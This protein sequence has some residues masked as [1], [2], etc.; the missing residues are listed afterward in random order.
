M[1]SLRQGVNEYLVYRQKL[2]FKLEDD[3][4]LLFNFV[5]FAET[6]Q[7]KHITTEL[8]MAFATINPNGNPARWTRRLAV[9]RRFAVYWS[10][11]DLKTEIP[12]NL[13]CS[14]YKRQAPYIYTDEEITKLLECSE[15]CSSSIDQYAYFIL[16]GLLVVSGMRLTEA[17]SLNCDDVDLEK[18]IITIRQ[19]KFR[20]SRHIPIHESTVAILK[21]FS[22]YRNRQ[23]PH[24]VISRFL[25]NH[26]GAQLNACTVRKIFRNRLKK[27]GIAKSKKHCRS[28]RIM[29][30]RH[31]F[32][33]RTLIRW[34]KQDVSSIDSHIYLLSTY[35]GHV[36]PSN[37]YWYLTVTPEL[38]KLVISRCEKNKKK[39]QS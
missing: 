24:S 27:I 11:T 30:L 5:C 39:G 31:T 29:D 15:D 22:N 37:T 2:G 20:K 33:V 14:F 36:M 19:S 1:I 26:K 9:V 3:K 4:H 12:K 28:P 38:L 17:L 6:K 25:V 35:L 23:F 16:F 13:L 7:I 10:A 18:G 34:Y 32:C 21:K 8:A